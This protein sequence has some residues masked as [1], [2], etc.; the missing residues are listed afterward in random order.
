MREQAF[1]LIHG[2]GR[3]FGHVARRRTYRLR[4][5]E[6][7]EA[8]LFADCK[9]VFSGKGLNGFYQAWPVLI[10]VI[11]ENYAAVFHDWPISL[12]VS[13]NIRFIVAGIHINQVGLEAL[14]SEPSRGN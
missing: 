10:V 11:A 6:H 2:C 4:F 13:G 8:L 7:P 1:D 12:Q 9:R 14:M 3:Q 5:L